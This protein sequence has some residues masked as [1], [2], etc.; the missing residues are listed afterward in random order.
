[1]ANKREYIERLQMA[2]HHLHKANAKHVGSEQVHET[3]Q[4]QTVWQGDVEAFDLMGHAKASRCYA[5]SYQ[6]DA[7]EHIATA[8]GLPPVKTALDAV[9]VH[10]V[11]ESRKRKGK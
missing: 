9:R 6:D 11:G 8:L 2:I 7:G 1:M 10:I 5:W 3:F 4:G